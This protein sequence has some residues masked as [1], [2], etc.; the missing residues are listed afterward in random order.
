MSTPIGARS[1]APGIQGPQFFI[2]LDVADKA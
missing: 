1:E 2:T